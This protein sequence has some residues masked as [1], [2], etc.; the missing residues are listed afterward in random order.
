[1][2]SKISYLFNRQIISFIISFLP[3]FDRNC[4]RLIRY[5]SQF[6]RWNESLSAQ[7][8]DLSRLIV[9]WWRRVSL[10]QILWQW[11]IDRLLSLNHASL[12][13]VLSCNNTSGCNYLSSEPWHWAGIS[14]LGMVMKKEYVTVKFS[15]SVILTEH[16][17]VFDLVWS[18]NK[19]FCVV[20]FHFALD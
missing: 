8:K 7:R 12:C 2:F 17:P 19:V 5:F 15:L 13:H 11:L 3:L 4:S 14:V 16:K 18:I 1:M 20:W 10:M 6:W 9:V